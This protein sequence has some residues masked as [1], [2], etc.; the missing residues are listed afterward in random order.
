[1]LSAVPCW[2]ARRRVTLEHFAKSGDS[3]DRPLFTVGIVLLSTLLIGLV[4]IA[5]ALP[6]AWRE[7]ACRGDPRWLYR[8]CCSFSLSSPDRLMRTFLAKNGCRITLTA[9]D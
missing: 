9:R 3:L 1:M 2:A 8:G 5:I 4:A 7:P 6:D